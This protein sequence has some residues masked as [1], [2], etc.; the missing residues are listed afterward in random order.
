MSGQPGVSTEDILEGRLQEVKEED[1]TDA[2]IWTHYSRVL[3]QLLQF[4]PQA[5]TVY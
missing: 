5:D 4:S 3:M 2:G 1:H